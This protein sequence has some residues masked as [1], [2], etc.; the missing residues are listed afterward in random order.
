MGRHKMEFGTCRLCEKETDLSF[1]HVPPRVAFNRKTT[2]LS[3]EFDDFIKVDNPLEEKYKGKKKQGGIGYNSLCK[4]CNSF[5]GSNYVN[6]Y[7]KWTMVGKELLE[8]GNFQ[9]VEYTALKQEPLKLLKQILSMFLAINKEWYLKAYPEISEFV[10]N[11][12]SNIL[13]DKYRVFTYLKNEGNIR[14][15]HH[16]VIYKP[17]LGGAVNCSEIAFAPY[18][19]VLLID[20][21][22]RLTLLNEITHFKNFALN[23]ELDLKMKMFKLPTY[24]HF[25]LD[26]RNKE[27]YAADIKKGIEA[28]NERTNKDQ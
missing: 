25:P 5:L 28:K 17:E 24:G 27:Q 7:T 19:Y 14:Y 12:E 4:D 21:D 9:I 15:S 2:Y 22:K 13:P 8:R 6:S 16:G 1:E 10:K 18:G 26:Y 20:F 3:V 23:D 11:P